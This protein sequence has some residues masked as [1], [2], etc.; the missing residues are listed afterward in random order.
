MTNN[1]S[2]YSCVVYRGLCLCGAKYIGET[3]RNT[4][5]RWSEHDER[6]HTNSECAK[7][8]NERYGH[9]FEW[10]ILSRLFFQTENIGITFH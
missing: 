9:E 6:V 1:I 8:L 2:Q 10:L 4:E 5:I 3:Q 7:H